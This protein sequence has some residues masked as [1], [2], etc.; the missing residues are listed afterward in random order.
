MLLYITCALVILGAD[1]QLRDRLQHEQCVAV[2]AHCVN[3]DFTK[4]DFT[5]ALLVDADFTGTILTGAII[6]HAQLA[7]LA[8]SADAVLPTTFAPDSA[9]R[10]CP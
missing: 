9:T 8:T 4:V 7:Q 2:R 10:E 1:L 3:T 6:T 5:R